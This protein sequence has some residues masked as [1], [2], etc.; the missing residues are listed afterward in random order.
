MYF[1]LGKPEPEVTWFKD[2]QPIKLQKGDT[3]ISMEVD[4]EE[5]LYTLEIANANVRI[6]D[7][8][9]LLGNMYIIFPSSNPIIPFKECS[10][11]GH[12][13]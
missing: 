5:S 3:K 13:S 2:G 8:I 12:D 9:S 10:T 6:F 11:C 4:G 7:C 1:F